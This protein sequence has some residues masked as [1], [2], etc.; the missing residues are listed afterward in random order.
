[1]QSLCYSQCGP[2]TGSSITWS[3]LEMQTLGPQPRCSHSEGA[4]EA[5]LVI[6]LL[7]GAGEAQ[8]SAVT[9][10][11]GQVEGGLQRRV[12]AHVLLNVSMCK[13]LTRIQDLFIIFFS[14]EVKEVLL[15]SLLFS[16]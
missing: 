5:V 12:G 4:Y 15:L 10:L 14:F 9:S 16:Q 8:L 3:L 2:R 1:M 6:C 11:V 7:L 13:L